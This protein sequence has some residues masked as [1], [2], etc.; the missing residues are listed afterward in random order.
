[1]LNTFT[2]NLS[3]MALINSRKLR[4]D[5]FYSDSGFKFEYD[6]KHQ[7]VFIKFPV[8]ILS[9]FLIIPLDLVFIASF[10][11]STANLSFGQFSDFLF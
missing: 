8:L 4:R 2:F 7:F 5:K 1:M 11:Y 3:R 10:W 9:L 6:V